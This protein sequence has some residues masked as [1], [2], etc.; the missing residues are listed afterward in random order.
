M[1][2]LC[3]YACVL[4]G[5]G[6]IIHTWG[7]GMVRMCCATNRTGTLS[8]VHE[9]SLQ[10]I[11]CFFFFDF[12]SPPARDLFKRDGQHLMEL[13]EVY[14]FSFPS[15]TSCSWIFFACWRSWTVIQWTWS[16]F[17]LFFNKYE[18]FWMPGNPHGLERRTWAV[19]F[20]GPLAMCFDCLTIVWCVTCM[21]MF[22][23]ATFYSKTQMYKIKALKYL[24]RQSRA[25]VIF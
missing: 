18:Y 16:T 7:R 23:F 13:P 24:P 20:A 22:P 5:H 12:F 8:N 9:V 15:M 10:G 6:W 21:M 17:R 11:A 3:F 4:S 1:I 14:L 19:T 25:F 2:W